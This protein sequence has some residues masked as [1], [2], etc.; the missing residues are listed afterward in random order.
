MNK[1]F[2]IITG[3]VFF[4][5]LEDVLY[6][7]GLFLLWIRHKGKIKFTSIQEIYDEGKITLVGYIVSLL[8]FFIILKI[9]S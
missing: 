6:W 5:V 7:I 9:L 8:I 1:F 3:I 4:I 2:I